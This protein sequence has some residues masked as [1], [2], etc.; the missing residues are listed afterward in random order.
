MSASSP[1]TRIPFLVRDHSTLA[2]NERV[3]DWAR[4]S[5]VPV[6]ERLRYLSIVSSNLDEFFEVR[7]AP[8]LAAAKTNETRGLYTAHSFEALSA[9]VHQLV[10]QQYALYNDELLPALEKKGIKLVAH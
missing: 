8:Q 1:Q 3:M 2:F 9:Q 6:L 4:R 10:A 5:D 7:M